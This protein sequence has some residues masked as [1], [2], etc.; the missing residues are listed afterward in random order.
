MNKA[1]QKQVDTL[2]GGMLAQATKISLPKKYTTENYG[3]KIIITNTEN[4]AIT[5]VPLFA[6]RAVRKALSQLG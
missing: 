3:N 1:L 6:Y 5:I 4:S 2:Q